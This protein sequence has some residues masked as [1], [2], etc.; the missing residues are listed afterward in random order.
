VRFKV[1]NPGN[2]R[3]LNTNRLLYL[4]EDPDG[5]LWITTEHSGVVRY[6]NGEFKT[7]TTKDGLPDNSVLIRMF[8]QETK[9]YPLFFSLSGAAARFIDEKFSPCTSVELGPFEGAGHQTSPIAAWYVESNGLHRIESGRETAYLPVSGFK[10]DSFYRIFEDR[11]GNIWL[12][13]LTGELNR[14]R[15]GKIT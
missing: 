3:G 15:N 7:Y 6:K 12:R 9:S 2:T 13:M 5:S 8:K 14:Y 4:F 1:F 11:Q 10:H